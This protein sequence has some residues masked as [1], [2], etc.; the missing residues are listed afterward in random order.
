M[1]IPLTVIE[2]NTCDVII[3]RHEM[4]I[5]NAF[6]TRGRRADRLG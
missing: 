3:G 2:K 6:R 4:E 5:D 1:Q